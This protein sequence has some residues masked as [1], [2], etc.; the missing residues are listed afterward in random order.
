MTDIS[1]YSQ[2]KPPKTITKVS[3]DRFLDFTC[4]HTWILLS[5]IGSALYLFNQIARNTGALQ[6]AYVA[7]L[8]AIIAIWIKYFSTFEKVDRQK[9]KVKFFTAGI[10]G[11]HVINKFSVPV[12]FLERLVPIVNVH[13]S[14]IIEFK[15]GIFGVLM[16]THPVRISEEERPAHEKRLEKVLN[17]IPAN[18]HFKTIA[19][20]RLEPN[21]PIL[22]YLLEV[23]N[24]S[25]GDKA[26]D[27]HLAGLYTK[28]AEDNSQ[29]ISWKYY[30]FLSLGE[31]KSIASAKIQY[32]AIVPGL[33]K[34]MRAARLQPRIYENEN[35]ISTAYRTMFSEMVI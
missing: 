16:E 4:L 18:T 7:L 13:E 21:K 8:L 32:G 1:P 11:K 9:L 2:P 6:I 22:N 23:S 5:A 12:S 15:G 35:E 3:D 14:G 10:Q 20:S 27:L 17:G 26:T 25:N 19:C 33:L 29:V 28:V 31:Q 34:N 24:K 30:A